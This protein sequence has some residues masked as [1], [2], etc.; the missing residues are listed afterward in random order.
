MTTSH[1]DAHDLDKLARW[2]G[3]LSSDE[4]CR[5]P[6]YALFLVS[7]DDV[8]A[9]DVFRQFRSSFDDRAAQFQHLVIFGQHG[10]SRTVRDLIAKLGLEAGSFPVLVL[11]TGPSASTFYALP[12][13]VGSGGDDDRRW[14]DVLAVVETAADKGESELVLGTIPGLTCPEV[15]TRSLH[16]LVHAV[17][18]NRD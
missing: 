12:L 9:H 10:V 2:H 4:P 16:D 13:P 3:S 8:A 6:V 7:A 18:N 11:V 15:E 5:F 17:L 1:A 14:V